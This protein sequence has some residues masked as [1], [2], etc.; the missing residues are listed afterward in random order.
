MGARLVTPRSK[1]SEAVQSAVVRMARPVNT[2][3]GVV[4]GGGREAIASS[5]ADAHAVAD[6]R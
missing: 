4:K 6:Y 5:K 2:E 1:V 3:G